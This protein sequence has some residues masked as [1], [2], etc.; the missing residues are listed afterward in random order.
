MGSTQ[1]GQ[2]DDQAERLLVHLQIVNGNIRTLILPTPIG[3]MPHAISP[4]GF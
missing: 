1:K 3:N 2:R 4:I